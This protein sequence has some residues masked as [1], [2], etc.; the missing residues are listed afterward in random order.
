MMKLKS[1]A[2]FAVAVGVFLAAA[3]TVS[4]IPRTPSGGS[5]H[6]AADVNYPVLLDEGNSLYTIIVTGMGRASLS[7]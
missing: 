5:R 1:A 7:R 4:T 2:V 6:G 3:H